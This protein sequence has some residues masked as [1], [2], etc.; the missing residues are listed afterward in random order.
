MDRLLKSEISNELA[1][2]TDWKLVEETWIERKFSFNQYLDGIKFVD[3]V[4]RV[5]ENKQHHP[6]ITINYKKVS[7]KFSSWQEKG[8][9]S[10]DFEIAKKIDELYQKADH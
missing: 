1:N 7:I 5:A 3:Q 6:L 8:L 10:L 4:A 2:L 9:T